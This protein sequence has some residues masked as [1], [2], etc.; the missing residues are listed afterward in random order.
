[1]EAKIRISTEE[2]LRE[3]S[4]ERMTR[5][6]KIFFSPLSNYFN[7]SVKKPFGEAKGYR[8]Y[9]LEVLKRVELT[10]GMQLNK[11]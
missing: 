11:N 1:M 8:V 4:F 7:T 6:V 5:K 10:N 2:T 9:L 3:R